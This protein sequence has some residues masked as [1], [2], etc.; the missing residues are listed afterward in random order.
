MKEFSDSGGRESGDAS[1]GRFLEPHGVVTRARSALLM[2]KYLGMRYDCIDEI[3]LNQI[4]SQIQALRP[5]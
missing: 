5:P 2:E 1:A 4:V 3:A